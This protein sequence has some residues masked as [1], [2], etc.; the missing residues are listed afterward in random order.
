MQKKT[1]V[2]LVFAGL[3]LIGGLGNIG[4]SIGGVAVGLVFSVVL[5]AW[6]VRDIRAEKARK[7]AEAARIEQERLAAKN[8]EKERQAEKKAAEEERKKTL[9]FSPRM[10]EA[11]IAY[12]YNVEIS[13]AKKND[14]TTDFFADARVSADGVVEIVES[15][16]IIG[17]VDNPHIV[18]ML[19]DWDTREDPYAV[20]VRHNG[21]ASFAF[22]RDNR[23]TQAW[24]KQ[25]V[26]KL[27]S[28]KSE[29]AQDEISSLHPGDEVD[30]E[31][32][33]DREN[34]VNVEYCSIKIGS[35]PARYAKK[36]SE[37]GAYGAYVE[38][39]KEDQSGGDFWY[40]PIIR[41]FW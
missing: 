33:Y 14:Y 38:E 19:K 2:K 17:T 5:S 20:I 34:A 32:N 27:T 41:I 12:R 15:E 26:V 9:Y 36:Y 1:I 35:L 37:E 25:D 7:A 39:I 28:Y 13:P 23:K 8:A 6:A 24:R 4:T 22:Y 16:N 31:E 18:G 29:A 11:P 3:C 10:G 21:G 40:V 30:L